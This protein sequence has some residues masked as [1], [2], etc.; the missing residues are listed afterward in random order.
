MN[1]HKK[2]NNKEQTI[3]KTTQTI[4]KNTTPKQQTQISKQ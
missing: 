2:D 4:N 3:I 1:P